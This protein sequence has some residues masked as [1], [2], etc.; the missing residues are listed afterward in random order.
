MA[1]DD[2]VPVSR[3]PMS[4]SR[5]EW[6]HIERVLREHKSNI[7]ETARALSMHRRNLSGN[8]PRDLRD[9][10]ARSLIRGG[11]GNPLVTVDASRGLGEELLVHGFHEILLLCDDLR[12][13]LVAML[14]IF[15]IVRLVFGPD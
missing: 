15:R 8:P 6:E 7:S 3:Q 2:Q 5:L 1:G 11:M 12:A 9:T 4:I 10:D 14:A 13:E